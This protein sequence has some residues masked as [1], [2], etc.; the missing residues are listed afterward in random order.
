MSEEIIETPVTPVSPV[1]PVNPEL[2][3]PKDANLRRNSTGRTSTSNSKEKTLPIYLRA[4]T[5][6]C[7]D[8][9]KYGKEHTFETK[10]RHPLMKRSAKTPSDVQ[11][12]VKTA[13]P[14]ERK[15]QLVVKPKPS[16]E[17]KTP[18]QVHEK[19]K[20]IK[21][22]TKIPTR[23]VASPSKK[24]GVTAKLAISV[25]KVPSPSKKIVVTAKPAI[26]LTKVSSP[27]KKIVVTAKPA[28]SLT[29]VSSPSKKLVI[30]AK[31]AISLKPK[32]VAMRLSTSPLKS[33]GGLGSRG[34]SNIKIV[35]NT[36]RSRIV[37]KK[38]LVKPTA[39]LS[40]KPSANRVATLNTKNVLK[41]ATPLKD[42]NKLR[43]VEPKQPNAEKLREKTLYVIE[44]N[45]EN[46]NLAA[47]VNGRLSNQSSEAS[48]SSSSVKKRSSS[49]SSTQSSQSYREEEEEN[50]YESTISKET[51]SESTHSKGTGSESTHSKETENGKTSQA[52]YRRTKARMVQPEEKES[53][54]KQNFRRGKVV[55]LQAENNGARKLRFRQ[56]RVL[57]DNQ[58]GKGELS[59][60][61]FRKR[62][63]VDNE[64]GAKPESEKVVLR[65][66]DM[67][68]KKDEQVLIN[69]VIEA[70]ASKLVE[71]R[72][73]KVKALVGAFETVISLHETKPSATSID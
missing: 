34:N 26:S 23:E 28:I 65:H 68:G 37:E 66:Q 10:G 52:K 41:P 16:P 13:T 56:G 70:T 36:A 22:E 63:E 8:L 35:N 69:N 9:C 6:S 60:K 53:A 33:S 51:G 44:P 1:T 2:T 64:N 40:R 72:K 3:K 67:Q 21:R 46:K 71:T 7:H 14:P 31:P 11:Y 48:S 58:N 25:T 30:T 12:P 45:P 27:S 4:S 55:T 38:P 32:P 59:K 20:I 24:I 39:S 15:N 18:T 54:R 49:P 61:S 5:S 17:L 19:P 42:Q 50:G 47:S 29:K 73:S 43:K 57:G 62:T